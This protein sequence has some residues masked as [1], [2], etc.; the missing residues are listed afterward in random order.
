MHVVSAANAARAPFRMKGASPQAIRLF[1]SA[2]E[3]VDCQQLFRDDG[4]DDNS[5]LIEP[6]R[7]R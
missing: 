1:D 3:T 4:A 2:P 6:A 5:E 7:L